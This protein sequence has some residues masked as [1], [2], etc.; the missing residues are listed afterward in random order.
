MLSIFTKFAKSESGAVTVDWVVLTAGV[1]FLG[2]SVILLIGAKTADASDNL[3]LFI[4]ELEIEPT[5]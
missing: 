1:V 4:G 2:L 5:F 3:G